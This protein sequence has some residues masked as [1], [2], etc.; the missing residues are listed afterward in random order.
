MQRAE[1]F[2]SQDN[3]PGWQFE[4]IQALANDPVTPMHLHAWYEDGRIV[5]VAGLRMTTLE[6]M[7]SLRADLYVD[8]DQRRRGYGRALLHDVESYA[9]EQG[10]REII[11]YAMEGAH[12]VGRGPNR[13]F[14]PACGYEL[15]DDSLRMDLTWPVDPALRER[16]ER[17]WR[18]HALDYEIITFARTTP[19]EWL[20]ERARLAATMLTAAPSALVEPEDERWNAERVLHPR[21]NC[22]RNGST[23]AHRRCTTSREQHPRGLQRTHDLQGFN[24]YRLPVGHAGEPAASWSSIGWTHEI[25]KFL[26]PG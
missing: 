7:H 11:V 15:G 21:V 18:P 4:E 9:H 5:G 19:E 10:R 12:E 16:L 17:D 25:G 3:G 8:P 23:V 13:A 14:A 20:D 1:L 6:N 2:R 24:R 22:S 26:T